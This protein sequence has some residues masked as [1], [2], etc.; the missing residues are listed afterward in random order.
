MAKEVSGF[1]KV[2]VRGGAANPSPPVGPA[3]GAK[4]VNIMDFCKQ[5]NA[6]TQEKQGQLLPCV[7]TVYSDKS[8]SFQIKTSPAAVQLLE[9]AKLKKGSSESNRTKVGKVTWDQVK[10]I[11]ENKLADLNTNKVESSM[12]QIAGTAQN[13]G[14]TIE[15]VAPWEN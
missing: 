2:Q 3:L 13:M 10:E 7:I 9:K 1:I 8:F 6:A 12:R 14:I 15:G 11:A 4:G 5:F